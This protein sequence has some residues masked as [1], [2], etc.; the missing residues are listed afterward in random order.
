MGTSP[1]PRQA[2]LLPFES[3]RSGKI[4]QRTFYVLISHTIDKR[5]QQGVTTVYIAEAILL[6]F[7]LK[8]ILE[9]I[10]ISS[11]VP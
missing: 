3:D 8:V 10:Y 1:A 5:V 4:Y 6:T 9:L 2:S 11:L 7:V